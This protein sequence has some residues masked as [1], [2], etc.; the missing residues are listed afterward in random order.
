M[1]REFAFYCP[2]LDCVVIQ[3]IVEGY[4]FAF[5]FDRKDLA[6]AYRNIEVCI[7]DDPLEI[8]SLIPLGE[9]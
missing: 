7:V 8:Y 3:I 4:R 9:V 5:E 1:I 6:I 2:E